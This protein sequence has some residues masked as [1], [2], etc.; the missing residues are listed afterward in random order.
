[1]KD[2][3]L[4]PEA[5]ARHLD[6]FLSLDLRLTSLS[7]GGCALKTEK[8]LEKGEILILRL[9]LLPDFPNKYESAAYR[10]AWTRPPKFPE[11]DARQVAGLQ[12]LETLPNSERAS[13]KKYLN[14][15]LDEPIV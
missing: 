8:Q 15:L 4:E 11:K 10:V 2:L 9:H 5:F 1:L 13:L 14:Y 7:L 6:T 3:E 12:L